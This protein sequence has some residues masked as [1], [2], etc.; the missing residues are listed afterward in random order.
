MDLALHRPPIT[1]W[2][3]IDRNPATVDIVASA[4]NLYQR[5]GNGHIWKYTGTPL[6]GWQLLDKNPATVDI[7]AG[8]GQ[9]YQRHN[10]GS[11]W[12]YTGTP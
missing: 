7:R 1:G 5:H 4:G 11:I 6:T 10:S 8:G 2:Q 12:R 9:L 3:L